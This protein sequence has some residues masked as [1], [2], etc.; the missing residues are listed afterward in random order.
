M[1]GGFGSKFGADVWGIDRGRAVE[2]GG[3][4]PVKMFLDRVQEHLAAGNRPSATGKVKLGATKDGKL[5]AMIAETHGTGGIGGGSNFP[6]P[7][8][9]DVP[10]SSRSPHRRLR[11]LRRLPGDAAPGHPQ[12]CAIM[13]AAMDDLA[14]KLGIDPLE[15]RLKNLAAERLPDADLRGRGQDRGRADRLDGEPQAARPE[16]QGPDQARA[17]HGPAHLGRRRHAGQA[18]H[19]HD[20]PRRLGRAQERPR[21]TSAPAPGPSWR[22]SPPRSSG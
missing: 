17:R 7:Y 22:S 20:Q 19:L 2:E 15:F 8:V 12:G 1:G 6:L 3:G 11:Q 13:E 9:Y 21:R 5:V 4:R 16:R 18:G 10:A 14:D